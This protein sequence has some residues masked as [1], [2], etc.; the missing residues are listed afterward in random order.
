MAVIIGTSRETV[1]ACRPP[2]TPPATPLID[3]TRT[4]IAMGDFSTLIR[5]VVASALVGL[6]AYCGGH[7]VQVWR[8]RNAR[9]GADP[10]RAGG[11]R[12][13][14]TVCLLAGL[15]LAAGAV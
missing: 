12:R 3:R 4:N 14:A 6:L 11:G 7:V 2:A 9:K 1:P 10:N 13:V 5:L 15:V 8:K